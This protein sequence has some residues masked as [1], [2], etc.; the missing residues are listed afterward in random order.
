MSLAREKGWLLAWDKSQWLYLL[1][2]A[3]QIQGQT[4]FPSPIAQACLADDGSA[5]VVAG[6]GGELR[7][8]ALDLSLLWE[9]TLD[10]PPLAAALD[11]FGNFLA[12][13][14]SRGNVQG[15]D[16]AGNPLGTFQSPRPLLYLAFVPMRPVLVGS[17]DFGLVGACDLAGDWKWREAVVV[18]VGGL[19][20][21]GDGSSLLLACFSEGLQRFSADGKSQ[22]RIATP[23]PCRLVAQSFAG[24][25]L[26]GGGMTNKL[27]LFDREGRL[28]CRHELEQPHTALAFAALGEA[29]FV[30]QPGAGIVKFK[31][32]RR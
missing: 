6:K 14:D 16:A 11:P 8:L 17:A 23:K 29:V 21:N 5:L 24:D 31:V 26:L 20:V 27:F 30:G 15:F 9:R 22:I 19:S 13:A 12:I 4:R 25:R 7:R 18:N 28:Q 1:N 2:Q 10:H 32:N 3:G